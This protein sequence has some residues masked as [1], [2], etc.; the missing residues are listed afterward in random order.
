MVSPEFLPDLESV[1]YE[2]TLFLRHTHNEGERTCI[3]ST[4][5][6]Q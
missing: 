6:L 5:I 4:F 2:K 1:V 3:L